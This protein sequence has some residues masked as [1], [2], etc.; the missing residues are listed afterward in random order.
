M[1]GGGGVGMACEVSHASI[2]AL[3]PRPEPSLGIGCSFGRRILSSMIF[4]RPVRTYSMA[5]GHIR[6]R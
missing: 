5:S 4:A 3:I 1:R 2:P 6:M